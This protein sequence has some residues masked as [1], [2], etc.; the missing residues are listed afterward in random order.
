[1]TGHG[2][3]RF[4]LVGNNIDSFRLDKNDVGFYDNGGKFV[5]E[6]GAR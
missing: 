4:S 3:S 5:V 6:P 1:V 2:K